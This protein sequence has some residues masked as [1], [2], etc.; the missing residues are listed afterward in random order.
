MNTWITALTLA[1]PQQLA[2]GPPVTP[3]ITQQPLDQTV[4]QGYPASFSAVAVGSPPLTYQWRHGS[5]ILPTGT[6]ATLLLPNAQ[7][8]DA[9]SYVVQV[10]NLAG[11][12]N[13]RA[14]ILTVNPPPPVLL[15]L[16]LHAPTNL[17]AG[18]PV[19]ISWLVTNAGP[20][21]AISPW[22]ETLLL[23]ANPAGAN[24][25]TLFTMTNNTSLAAGSAVTRTQTVILPAGLSGTYWLAA[26]VDS[27]NQVAEGYG[28]TNNTFV[29]AQPILI[30]SPD[31]QVSMVTSPASAQFGQT[32]SVTW[33]VR[34]SGSTNATANWSDRLYLS[35]SSTSLLNT[36]LLLTTPALSTLAAGAS[37]TNSQTVTLPL[38]SDLPPGNYFIVAVADSDQTQSETDYSNNSRSAPLTLTLPP[39]PDLSITNLNA[40]AVAHLGD[41]VVVT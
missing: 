17:S 38:S 37:Y 15:V 10:A 28:E 1:L 29:A 33:A 9:G 22:Q 26:Q 24:A 18:Q 7:V 12:T 19:P 41:P 6:N 14:A 11:V 2:I 27:A 5:A 31:L 35:P 3:F 25:T 16:G 20:S 13:S 36:R 39:L 32:V 8:S 34:N 23:A 30:Q 4:F 21:T 40:P